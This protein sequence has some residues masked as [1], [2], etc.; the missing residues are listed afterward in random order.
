MKTV[1]SLL[2]LLSLTATA[3]GMEIRLT[4]EELAL[5]SE[6]IVSGTVVRVESSTT[7]PQPGI[8][9]KATI[10]IKE[11][12]KGPTSDSTGQLTVTLPGGRDPRGRYRLY[13]SGVPEL[14]PGEEVVVF[15][16]RD[17]L[18]RLQLMGEQGKY[19]LQGGM[20]Y[21]HGLQA[22][23]AEPVN[24]FLNKLRKIVN[25]QRPSAR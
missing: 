22:E 2:V 7:E 23:P 18:G 5:S 20:A 9:T 15:C 8:F 17:K 10:Q 25:D 6:Q 21:R 13:V 14:K 3:R 12:F 24:D 1:C 16:T 4:L 11:R 19:L